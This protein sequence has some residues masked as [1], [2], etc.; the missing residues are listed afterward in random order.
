MSSNYYGTHKKDCT[1]Y[2][3][4][5]WTNSTLYIEEGHFGRI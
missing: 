5:K 4:E 2:P 1:F 3:V